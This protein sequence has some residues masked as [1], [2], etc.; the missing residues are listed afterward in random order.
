VAFFKDG[1]RAEIR[2]SW[3]NEMAVRALND[4]SAEQSGNSV[5]RMEAYKYREDVLSHIVSI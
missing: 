5:I 4:Y 1:S 2:P 3:R